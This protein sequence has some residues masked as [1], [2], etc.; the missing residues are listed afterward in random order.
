MKRLLIMIGLIAMAAGRGSRADVAAKSLTLADNERA[1]CTIVVGREDGMAKVFTREYSDLTRAK[2]ATVL[3]DAADDLAHHLNEMGGL[4]NTTHRIRVVERAAAARTP[5]RILLGSAAI[6]AHGLEAEAAALP[7]PAYIYRTIGNDLVIFGSSSKGAANGVYGFLQNELG[8]RWFGPQELFQVIPRRESIRITALDKTGIPSFLGRL[9]HSGAFQWARRHM[10]MVET[11]DEGE[12]FRNTSHNFWRIFPTSRYAETHPEYYAQRGRLRAIDPNNPRHFSLCF[13][14]PDVID[15]ATKAALDYF[16]ANPRH[17]TFSLGINDSLAYCDCDACA[18]LQPERTYRGNRVASDMYYHFVNAVAR[19]VAERFPDCYLGVIAY[20]DVTAPPEGDIEPNVHVVLVNDISE[21]YDASYRARDEE[22]VRAWE[23]KNVT[24]GLYYY[25]QLAKLTP[26]YFPRLLASELKDKRN[27]GFISVTSEMG[28][29]WPWHGPM[30]YAEARLLWDVTLSVDDL[31]NEYFVTLFGP[32]AAPMRAL[33]DR[34]EEIH[35]RPRG[36]R[37]LFEHYKALQFRPY[38]ADDLR[39]MRQ[40]LAEAHAAI[41]TLGVVSDRDGLEGRRVAY[42]SNGLRI[43][44]DMLDGFTQAERLQAQA[45][46]DDGAAMA[47]LEGAAHLNALMDRHVQ[48]YRETII[49]DTDLP[50]RFR[51]DTCTPV[52]IQWQRTLAETVAN[53]LVRLHRAHSAGDIA[54]ARTVARLRGEI[55]RYTADSYRAVLFRL[56]SGELEPGPNRLL[57]PGFEIL[58]RPSTFPEHLD[59]SATP[60]YGWASWQQHR[61]RG[62]FTIVEAPVHNGGRAGQL[63][64]VGNGSFITLVP[65]LQEGEVYHVQAYVLNTAHVTRENKPR[66]R[67]EVRWLDEE[68]HWVRRAGRLSDATD[69]LDDWI[70]LETIVTVPEGVSTAVILIFATPLQDDETVYV[71][72]VAFRHLGD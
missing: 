59:W 16:S 64:G 9:V 23:A 61:N 27:R 35:L 62:D 46:V 47:M 29:G 55:D 30:A 43:F 31:L 39:F 12:P 44:L 67:L 24:L 34:F 57:N 66:V 70:R 1:A 54:D 40:R 3:H 42:V 32:A 28:N 11:V 68:N 41:E 52:R 50:G 19:R 72:D 49:S 65:D 58:D 17:H 8:V 21:Y 63:R 7:Y 48:L 53:A 33:Y 45:P 18:R 10:R 20:N 15:I 37:F 13:S 2:P 38:T 60:A 5:V 25:T 36:G 4:W 69:R 71:D 26:A 51:R 56:R 14:S 6:E 22:R